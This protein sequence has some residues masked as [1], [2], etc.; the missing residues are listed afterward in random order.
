[1]AVDFKREYQRLYAPKAT[2]SLIEVEPIL[3]FAVD[4]QGDP[5]QEGG[6][7]QRA[8]ELLYALSYTLKMS[9]KSGETPA[10]YY[11]Y[12]VPPLEGLWWMSD[13]HAGVDFTRKDAFCWVAMIR[14]RIMSIRRCSIGCAVWWSRRKDCIRRPFI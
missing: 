4:G 11:D 13:G 12:V 14:C 2:P 1:M 9:K 6:A 8:V 7:Y 3:F 10:G 5:N